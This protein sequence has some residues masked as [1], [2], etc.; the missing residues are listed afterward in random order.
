[1]SRRRC[2]DR[3]Q[4][5]TLNP[6]TLGGR[7]YVPVVIGADEAQMM[8]D[9]KLFQAEGDLIR[10]LFG[11]DMIVASVLPRTNTPLDMMHFVQADVPLKF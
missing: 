4:A 2:A 11:N 1:M 3:L 8:Q 5:D 6:A 9:E 7:P 10:N